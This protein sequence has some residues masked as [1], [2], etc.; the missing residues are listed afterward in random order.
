MVE[1]PRVDFSPMQLVDTL[2]KDAYVVT[3]D[4]GRRVYTHGFIAFA[5]GKIVAVGPMKDCAFT[6]TETIDGAGKLVMP[7]MTNAHNHLNQ[8]FLRGYNDDRWPVLDIPKAVA[9]VMKQLYAVSGRTDEERGH[10]L[11]RLHCLELIKAG[12]TATH[13]EHF[14]NARRD[15]VDGSWAAL[16]DSGMRGFLARCIVNS[17]MVPPAG[18]ETVEQG[19]TEV[20]RL[21]S[22]FNSSRIAVA[23][24]FVNYRFLTD[25]EDMRRIHQGAQKLGAHLDIDMTDNSRGADLKKRGFDGGQV[26]Y[27]RTFDLLTAPIYAGKAVNVLPHEFEILA[28]HDCRLS[29]VPILRQF[30]GAGLPLHRLL[31][32]GVIPG[33]GTDAPMVTD[34]QNPFEVMRQAIL[35]QNLA[36]ARE[37]AQGQ[38]PPP[39]EHW[40]TS[41][42]VIEMATLGGARTL[43]MD[44]VTGSLEV[45]KAADCVMID[46]DQ[47]LMTPHFDHRRTLGTLVW[48]GESRIV[49]TVFVEGKKLLENGRSTV[50]NETEV[51]ASA[52]KVLREIAAET[53]LPTVLPP[54]V[55]GQSHRGW[56]YL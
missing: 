18:H 8:V 41:E 7:G 47:V 54:R 45:G 10:A 4:A 53:D 46:L 38:P 25:P 50:W 42:T 55:A 2:I 32:L 14:T 34:N 29:L 26:E 52:E 31:K 51:I 35:G 27:Y 5:G 6:A 24:G 1:P 12:Y 39:A 11:T 23:A 19:L 9:A 17:E 49:D 56:T 30:D 28:A 36:V 44:A 43:F 15:S 21:R 37:R 22:K 16:K 33:L 48:A 40:A 13:D 3:V 20:E